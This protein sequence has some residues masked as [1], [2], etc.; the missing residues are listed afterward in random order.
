M[1]FGL[2]VVLT[3]LRTGDIVDRKRTSNSY[4][5]GQTATFGPV[6]DG[7]ITRTATWFVRIA[8]DATLSITDGRPPSTQ[9]WSPKTSMVY[10]HK[11]LSAQPEDPDELEQ[12]LE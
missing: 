5:D 8:Q 2:G 9:K 6:R 3:G 1:F 10:M 11:E 7:D 12:Q 4:I